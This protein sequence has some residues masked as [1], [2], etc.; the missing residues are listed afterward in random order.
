MKLTLK[1]GG[2]SG[3]NAGPDTTSSNLLRNTHYRVRVKTESCR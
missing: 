1:K 3:G 2:E